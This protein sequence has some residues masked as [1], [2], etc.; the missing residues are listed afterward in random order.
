MIKP[1]APGGD[2]ADDPCAR[3]A[4]AL[5]DDSD[6]ELYYIGHKHAYEGG[7]YKYKSKGHYEGGERQG[8]AAGLAGRDHRTGGG[9][10]GQAVGLARAGSIGQRQAAGLGKDRSEVDRPDPDLETVPQGDLLQAPAAQIGP[11]RVQ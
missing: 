6:V 4:K 10:I 7:K 2:A 3:A 1:L 5:W 11:G 8:I 9:Q